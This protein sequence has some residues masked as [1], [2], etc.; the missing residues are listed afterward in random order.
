MGDAGKMKFFYELGTC[1]IFGPTPYVRFFF[2]FE[3][4]ISPNHVFRYSRIVYRNLLKA[5]TAF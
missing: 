3:V 5:A 2:N 1:P 4:P